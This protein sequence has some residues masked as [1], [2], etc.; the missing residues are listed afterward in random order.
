[1]PKANVGAGTDDLDWRLA[2]D[3]KIDALHGPIERR[4]EQLID[5]NWLAAPTAMLDRKDAAVRQRADREAGAVPDFAEPEAR[6]RAASTTCGASNP[7][8]LNFAF[9]AL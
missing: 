9:R 5:E 2:F 7:A 6:R 3:A 1:M 8:W 4:P